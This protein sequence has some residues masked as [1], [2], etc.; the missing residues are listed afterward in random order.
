MPVEEAPVA[1]EVKVD[2]PNQIDGARVEVDG[3]GV[4]DN[5]ST[6]ELDD[7]VLETYTAR[8]GH[9]PY[10]GYGVTITIDGEESVV[11]VDE[12]EAPEEAAAS[13]EAPVD[14]SEAQDPGAKNFDGMDRE[15]LLTAAKARGWT[16][17]EDATDDAIRAALKEADK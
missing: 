13:D 10:S 2:L 17:R 9:P 11:P 1:T 15:G 14:P 7:G 5:G 6:N 4:F 3:L 8:N 12:P 16:V